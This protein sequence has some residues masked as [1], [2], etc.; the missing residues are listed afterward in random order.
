LLKQIFQPEGEKTSLALWHRVRSVFQPIIKITQ[1]RVNF[2]E[3]TSVLFGRPKQKKTKIGTIFLGANLKVCHPDFGPFFN[4]GR[5][6]TS[7]LRVL[8]EAR[9]DFGPFGTECGNLA[10]KI[11][12][13]LSV[14]KIL[15]FIAINYC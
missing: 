14:I 9:P 7:P 2:P 1:S 6:W 15:T 10:M 4:L 8:K 12:D 13:P 5:P 11:N 3:K